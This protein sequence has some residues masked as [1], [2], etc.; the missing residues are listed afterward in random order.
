MKKCIVCK[1]TIR[2]GTKY[3]YECRPMRAGGR[4][5][6]PNKQEYNPVTGEKIPRGYTRDK[7][8]SELIRKN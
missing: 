5:D 3:C 6:A 7:I 8:T 1:R 4:S 2:T